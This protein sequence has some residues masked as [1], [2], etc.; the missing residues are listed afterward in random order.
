MPRPKIWGINVS[1]NDY[2]GQSGAK[3]HEQRILSRSDAVQNLRVR[4]FEGISSSTD[5]ILDFGCGT[6]G[7]VS[8]LAA[9]RRMGV[10]VNESAGDEA[11]NRGIEVFGSIDEV[12]DFV[13]DVV[14]SNHA[15]EHVEDPARILRGI[16]RVLKPGGRIRVVLPGESCL[17]DYQ[18]TSGE[19]KDKHLFA[20]T[21][22]AFA[23]LMN[24][25]GFSDVRAVTCA[26]PSDARGARW[27][28]AIPVI[29]KDLEWVRAVRKQKINIIADATRRN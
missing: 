28:R 21:A 9:Q 1:A 11:R 14:I 2:T 29:G 24:A 23:H 6:G 16:L 19:D 5:C 26:M 7:I 27:L 17:W 22:R 18:A 13:A 12:P 20:W 4:V 8:R 15:L 3:Y 10:E 25:S